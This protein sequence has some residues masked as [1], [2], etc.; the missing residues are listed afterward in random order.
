MT[1]LHSALQ[2]LGPVEWETIPQD[3][4]QTYL[5]N[6]V[7]QTQL[8]VDSVPPPPIEEAVATA[9][10]R[11][12]TGASVASSSSEISSSSARSTLSDP[13]VAALQKEWGKPFRFAAK[14]NPLDMAVYK[15][16]AK[17][18]K[19]SWF[20][21]RSV[22]EGLGFSRWKKG[23]EAEFQESLEVQ[24]LPGEGNIRGIGGEKM[25]EQ[26]A[27]EGMGK[28]EVFHLSAQFPG[29]TAPRDFVTLLISSSAALT[30]SLSSS[31]A[32]LI[33]TN[34]KNSIP[35]HFAIVSKPC[36]HPECPAREG[37]IRGQ[38]ESIEFIR[39]IPLKQHNE[40][41]SP[42][43]P[44]KGRSRASSSVIGKEAIA[45]NAR[46]TNTLPARLEESSHVSEG[47]NSDVVASTDGNTSGRARGKT[48]SYEEYPGISKGEQA[49]SY[50]AND[51]NDS[52]AGNGAEANP[53]EWI[54]ITR[55]DPGGSVPRWM[56]ERGTPSSIVADAVKFLDWACKKEH[57]DSDS[58]EEGDVDHDH[59]E[60]DVD[61][62]WHTNSHLAGLDATGVNQGG[63]PRAH[64]G[65]PAVI[66]ENGGIPSTVVG[67]VGSNIPAVTPT[68][69]V[70]HLPGH[71]TI[72]AEEELSIEQASD[73]KQLSAVDNKKQL[74][75][76]TDSDSD[77][78]SLD[79]FATA[80]GFGEYNDTCD[81]VASNYADSSTTS[82]A[83][84]ENMTP[85]EKELAKLNERKKRLDEQLAKA[86]MRDEK[87][88]NEVTAKET[89]RIIKAQEKHDR[90]V[91]KQEEKY[92]REVQKIE[93][94]KAKEAKKSEERRRKQ[95]EKDY[96]QKLQL[97]RDEMKAELNLLRKEREI[98]ITQ[99]GELQAENTALTARLGKL[100]GGDLVAELKQEVGRAGRLRARSLGGGSNGGLTRKASSRGQAPETEGK[101]N[102]K[103]AG[104]VP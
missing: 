34:F 66:G 46:K 24:G 10:P 39:E 99:V 31:T 81:E 91:A 87:R 73:E 3:N 93:A 64:E 96:K 45:R 26:K 6:I 59:H 14:D 29:P 55:S 36:I 71:Q 8:L 11:S 7:S 58:D 67:T 44:R 47:E 12:N 15:L 65:E 51:K 86:R 28:L 48:I 16:A 69:V 90:E 1:A 22:H 18:G 2:A 95:E 61:H 19:G 85:Q 56:V 32:E 75:A 5:K 94:K 40:Q 54:M 83:N 92:R 104:V 35:R 103:Y 13:A 102:V 89:E 9:R 80:T 60:I 52:E 38:Y 74:A 79:T 76:D 53:V 25:V 82:S 23:L 63:L 98:L 21:R 17:D 20:A 70:S 43:S 42:N 72:A 30:S 101:E 78:S 57:P 49:D 84:R 37:F 50:E 27:V 33:D 88:T 68:I 77:N 62:A 4:L 100:G 41:L 97:E